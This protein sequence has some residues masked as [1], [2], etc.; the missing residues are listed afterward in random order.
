[1]VVG[2]DLYTISYH[3]ILASDLSTFADRAWMP[4]REPEPKAVK[5]TKRKSK[6]KRR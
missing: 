6:K 3:G 2:D 1:M 5:K 4:L